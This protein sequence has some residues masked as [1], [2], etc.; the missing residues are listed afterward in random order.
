MRD[1]GGIEENSLAEH[2]EFD[3]QQ[4]TGLAE[5]VQ[6]KLDRKG[7]RKLRLGLGLDCIVKVEAAES[8]G[9]QQ[10][11]LSGDQ[12]LSRFGCAEVT[13]PEGSHHEGHTVGP[14]LTGRALSG[15][16]RAVWSAFGTNGHLVPVDTEMLE[17]AMTAGKRV[18]ERVAVV[19]EGTVWAAHCTRG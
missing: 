2:A 13:R 11:L 7:D 19:H 14:E 16:R 9:C 8:K 12:C 3:V 4:R 6:S 18:G 15:E 1:F 5:V 17:Y 10:G